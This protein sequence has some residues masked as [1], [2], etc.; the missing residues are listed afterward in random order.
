MAIKK[1]CGSEDFACGL[2]R[3]QLGAVARRASEP[4]RQS[5]IA[6]VLARI[7]A[8]QQEDRVGTSGAG[9]AA[10]YRCPQPVA[11]FHSPTIARQ[12]LPAIE[13]AP[14]EPVGDEQ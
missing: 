3:A 4:G 10:I 12:D 5:G 1:A 7:E 13:P 6:R 9:E 2:D 11:G 8:R 14:G